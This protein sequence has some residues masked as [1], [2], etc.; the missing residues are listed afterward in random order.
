[1]PCARIAASAAL[2]VV[3]AMTIAGCTADTPVPSPSP[4]A[5]FAVTG[6]G[7][8]RIGTLF[9]LTGA[10]AAQGQ[11]Q[12]AGVELAV[13]EVNAAGGVAESP[14]EVFHRNAVDAATATAGF[15]ALVERGVDV[16]VGP[17]SA[18]LVQL[19]G[20]D[21]AAAGVLIVSTSLVTPAPL[22]EATTAAAP[23]VVGLQP[24]G[25]AQGDELGRL[26]GEDGAARVALVS[27]AAET[28]PALAEGLRATLAGTGSR[29]AVSTVVA[30]AETDFTRLLAVID[31]SR[32]DVIVLT[33][34]AGASAD[35]V[36]VVLRLAEAGYAGDRLWF[37]IGAT[38]SYTGA[39]PPGAL[40]GARGLAPGAALP[41][42]F[43]AALGQ[44]DPSLPSST[45][46][47][48][49]HDAVVLAAL[50]A[51]VGGDDGGAAIGRFLRGV[52]SGG[53]PCRSFAECLHVLTTDP[54]IDFAGVSGALD[55]TEDGAVAT[56]GYARM[57]FTADNAPVAFV[58]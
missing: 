58:N 10:T 29:L 25:G 33:A 38:V 36:A 17:E 22:A 40:D 46:A 30:P 48:E 56:G 1:M 42:A 57:I 47:G 6:D 13:R 55:L 5:T 9:P 23:M 16:V 34:P 41:A 28:D 11:A 32:A 4:S 45:Y 21:A 3:A 8:L 52:S 20:A 7:V 12:V 39:L 50:A 54:D 14:V 37:A 49:A 44:S 19:L 31:K 35:V 24:A 18:E 2:L 53:I 15:A 51:T 27:I 26:L 43:V